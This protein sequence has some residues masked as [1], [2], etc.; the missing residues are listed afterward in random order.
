MK[1]QFITIGVA[2]MMALGFASCTKDEVKPLSVGQTGQAGSTDA[3]DPNMRGN[4]SVSAYEMN[5][6]DHT[7]FYTPYTLTFK[8][9]GVVVAAGT[10]KMMTGKWSKGVVGDHQSLSLDFGEVDPLNLL[11]CSDWNIEQQTATELKMRGTRG[12]DGSMT[13]VL[14]K[15]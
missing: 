5:G 15:K 12:D 11:N 7:D 1:N 3:E 6:V 8:G 10:G 9:E 4:W 14:K 2:M 13:L